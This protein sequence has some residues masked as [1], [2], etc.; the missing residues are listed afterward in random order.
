MVRRCHSASRR[1]GEPDLTPAM[2]CGMK[3]ETAKHGDE[4]EMIREADDDRE[5]M[6]D[7]IS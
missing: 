7:W 1:P 4:F 6:P 2:A 3:S 5:A